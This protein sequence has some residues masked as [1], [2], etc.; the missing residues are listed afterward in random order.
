MSIYDITGNFRIA[1]RIWAGFIAVLMLLIGVAGIG[2]WG[3]NS[4]GEHVDE[5][6]DSAHETLKM[7]AIDRNFVG[8]R[9]NQIVCV[10]LGRESAHAQL[11]K[12]LRQVRDGL[13]EFAKIPE[14]RPD[15][16]KEVAAIQASV[17]AYSGILDQ[18]IAERRRLGFGKAAS[19]EIAPRWDEDLD[20][21]GNAARDLLAAFVERN[22]TE[23]DHIMADADAFEKHTETLVLV[24]SA[25]AL[26]L[27]ALLAFGTDFSIS[28]PIRAITTIMNKL[29][30]GE[31]QIDVPFTT[32]KDEVGEM[33]SAVAVFKENL[34]EVE[35]LRVEQE[36]QKAEAE[37]EKK[38]SINELADKFETGVMGIVGSVSSSSHQLHASAQSLSAL[39]EQTH[40]QAASVASASEEASANVQTVASATE[41]LS[42]SISEI[43][44]RVEDSAHVSSNAVEEAARVNRMVQGLA[45]AVSK[46]GEVVSLINN[47]AAQTNLLALNATIEAA[48]A[49]EAGK[50][51]AVVAGEVKNLANQ[52]G[53]ATDE[54]SSQ[55]SAVQH[56]TREAV[57]G[58]EGIS[59][60][61]ARISEISTAIA[62]AV[63]EQSAATSEIS[64]SVQQAS[65]G[66]RQVTVNIAGVTLASTEAGAASHQVL[67]AA[68]NLSQQ[69]ER[70]KTD[71]H[72]FIEHLRVG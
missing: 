11:E 18:A 63:E 30:N 49:G 29:R 15:E 34:I 51:F 54:I 36:R 20:K 45:G 64:R 17:E 6:M 70:L 2:Y 22:Q 1:T 39:A 7:Q 48:R 60:T 56:A 40:R 41:E 66:T 25:L 21:A 68:T 5:I 13:A 8:V 28:N 59:G 23:L 19:G 35:N 53:R 3:V 43:T 61:I 42:S 38:R 14:L 27:G 62:T 26:A 47:I 33:A 31:R 57:S 69:S 9:R 46:I 4:V 72:R 12:R 32:L 10:Q 58:I 37:I 55:I 52:T 71:V 24:I 65:E 67:D 16:V 44:A 50:G